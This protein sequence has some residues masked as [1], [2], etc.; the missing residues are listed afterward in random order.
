MLRSDLDKPIARAVLVLTI[1]ENGVNKLVEAKD[2]PGNLI[3]FGGYG[4][5]F[6]TTPSILPA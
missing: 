2:A 5:D 1:Y 3:A 6:G 4:F